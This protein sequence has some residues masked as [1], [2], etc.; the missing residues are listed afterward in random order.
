M[1]AMGE[2]WSVSDL[3]RYVHDSLEKDFRLKDLRVRGEVSGFK[4][5]PSGHCYFTLKDDRAQVS[6]VMWRSRAEAQRSARR[7]PR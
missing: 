3:N 5:Y 7:P 4:A 1:Q 6:C 2:S